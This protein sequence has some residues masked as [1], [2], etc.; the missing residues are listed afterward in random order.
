M[1]ATRTVGARFV[2]VDALHEPAA[3][4]YERLGFRRPTN[5]LLLVQK[6]ADI[7][8][9]HDAQR[10]RDANDPP[11]SEEIHTLP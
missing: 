7:Q 11:E 3:V 9:A 1:E 8:A 4:F 6:V 2:V 10:P 5:S